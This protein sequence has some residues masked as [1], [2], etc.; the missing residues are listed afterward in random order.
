M[1]L[2]QNTGQKFKQH[3]DVAFYCIQRVTGSPMPNVF[4]GDY[5]ARA[6]PHI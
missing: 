3:V 6:A 4:A 1:D 5:T 2:L